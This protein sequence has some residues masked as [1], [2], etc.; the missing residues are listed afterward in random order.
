MPSEEKYI[1]G[2]IKGSYLD[3][4]HLYDTYAG[5]LYD[6][7]YKLL[8]S[9]ESAADILQETFITVW[10]NRSKINVELSFKSF[11]F[12]I[13]RNRIYNEFRWRINNPLISDYVDYLNDAKLSENSVE[14]KIDFDEFNT[15]LQKAKEKLTPRQREIFEKNKELGLPIS[16][17]SEELNIAE[18]TARNQLSQAITKLKSELKDYLTLFSIFF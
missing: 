7:I 6:Y 4:C 17:I 8:K 18:Q 15:R 3:F 12:T 5:H 2:L 9:K 14:K 13:A 16:E 10:Q 1:K 11:L